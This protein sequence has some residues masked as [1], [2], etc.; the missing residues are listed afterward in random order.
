MRFLPAALLAAGLILGVGL[1]FAGLGR[2]PVLLGAACLL[3]AGVLAARQASRGRFAAR[4]RRDPRRGAGHP[5]PA[6]RQRRPQ[7]PGHRLGG[8][9]GR[10]HRA[11]RGRRRGDL[12]RQGPDAHGARHRQ[13][14]RQVAD[15]V[16]ERGLRRLRAVRRPRRPHAGRRRPRGQAARDRP[17]HRPAA[18]GR[19]A[20]RRLRAPGDRRRRVRRGHPLPRGRALHG[21]GARAARRQR[22]LEGA[23]R[24]QRPLARLAADRPGPRLRPLDLARERG[25]RPRAAGRGPLRAARAGHREGARPRHRDRRR[26]RRDRQPVPAPDGGRRA[27][28]HGRG[29]GPPGVGA[30]GG[31]P[32]RRPHPGGLAAVAGDARRRTAA[33]RRVCATARTSRSPTRCASSTRAR[34][35]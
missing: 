30:P 1:P 2:L 5:A 22:P 7:R 23:R 4:P 12:V 17:R 6:A 24:L 10:A 19:A 31:R 28:G 13:R 34:A 14:R 27:V 15:R 26:P 32:R 3:A 11:R 18:L 29:H 25:H 21:R 16:P 9:R 8:A 33:R 20:R 35:A